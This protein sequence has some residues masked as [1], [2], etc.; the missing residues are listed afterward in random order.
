[1]FILYLFKMHSNPDNNDEHT[2]EIGLYLIKP[3]MSA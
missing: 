2:N 3:N 1:M